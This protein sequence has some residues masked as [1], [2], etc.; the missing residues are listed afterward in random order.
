VEGRDLAK[1]FDVVVFPVNSKKTK[2]KR[3]RIPVFFIWFVCLLTPLFVAASSY[4]IWHYSSNRVFCQQFRAKE[5][6]YRKQLAVLEKKVKG[7]QTQMTRVRDLD[8]K[9]RVIANLKPSLQK[10]T[11]AWGIGGIPEDAALPGEMANTLA[12]EEAERIRQLHY[13]LFR[14]DKLSRFE[15]KSLSELHK[16]LIS[17]KSLLDSTPSIRPAYGY[18]T[19]GFGFRISPFTG[20]KQFHEGLDIANRY[21]TSVIAPANGLIVFA[22]RRGGFGKLVIIGHGHGITTRYGH[23]SKIFVKVGQRVKRGE[24]IA[25]IGNTGRSTGP[26]LHYEVRLNGV[27]V[28]PKRYIL[29]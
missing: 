19:S 24:R 17:R 3:F 29:N 18:E 8:E 27:P 7:L 14:M 12:P 4:V 20:H 6:V 26:H 9:L 28:N 2:I 15:E 25:E 23:L 1:Y 22:G 11:S 21:G 5:G 13:D 10:G 16:V